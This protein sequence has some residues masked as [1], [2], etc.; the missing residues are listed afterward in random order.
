MPLCQVP[1]V[2]KPVGGFF[3]RREFLEFPGIG[4]DLAG[5][6]FQEAPVMPG[7]GMGFVLEPL[8]GEGG[9]FFPFLQEFLPGCPVV[10]G[11][12]RRGLGLGGD[13]VG[14]EGAQV[15]GRV[16]EAHGIAAHVFPVSFLG[17]GEEFSGVFLFAEPGGDA[18]AP[19]GFHDVIRQ[20]EAL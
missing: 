19:G 10:G 13:A 3:L 20:V 2:V 16:S 14:H 17:E 5:V 12:N 11:T 9:D 8:G 7:H 15:R 6:F 1:E 4:L 18:G